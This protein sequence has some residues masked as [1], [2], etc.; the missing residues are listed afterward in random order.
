[1]KKKIL[2]LMLCGMM[3]VSPISVYADEKDDRIAELEAQVAELESELSEMKEKYEKN[4]KENEAGD[5]AYTQD[6][7]TYKYLKNEIIED[8]TNGKRVVIYFEYTNESGQTTS[9]AN[10][11][12]IRAFQNGIEL[13]W[14]MPDFNNSIP[15]AD[16]AFKDIQSGTTT[17]IA[18]IYTI[19]DESDVSIEISPMF[20]TDTTE[21]GKYTFALNK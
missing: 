17:D 6:G 8:N 2:C 19:S 18:M 10:A 21:I 9:P 15:E 12:N 7:Y 11:L 14:M 3:A 5:F 4:E 20:Y 16:V 13:N 1:M